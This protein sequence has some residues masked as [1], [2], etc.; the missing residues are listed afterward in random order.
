MKK[1]LLVLYHSIQ[2]TKEVLLKKV[3]NH[4]GNYSYQFFDAN[5]KACIGCFANYA[6]AFEFFYMVC[7]FNKVT[8][9]QKSTLFKRG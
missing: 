3:P 4:F 5:G 7:G 1:E 8:Q 9:F 6:Y 2:H